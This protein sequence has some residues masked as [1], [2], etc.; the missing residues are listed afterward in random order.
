MIKT[1]PRNKLE[2]KLKKHVSTKVTFHVE[3]DG[4]NIAGFRD[5]L[6]P[7]LFYEW[8]FKYEHGSSSHCCS[9][10]HFTAKFSIYILCN[11]IDNLILNDFSKNRQKYIKL[12][13]LGFDN[14]S[15]NQTHFTNGATLTFASLK[16]KTQTCFA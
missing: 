16:L 5:Q 8:K 11:C 6:R 12:Y 4:N 15:V 3:D 13:F 10:N 14:A 2:E 7:L 9:R 1:N